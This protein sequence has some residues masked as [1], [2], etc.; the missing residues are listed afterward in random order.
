MTGIYLKCDKCG[1]T[2][3][4]E[5]VTTATNG[6]H[7]SHWPQL[8]AAARER[9]WTGPLTRESDSDRCPEC[10]KAETPNVKL[11]GERSESARTQG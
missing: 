4:G 2:L 3:G 8:Q 5:E 10:S 1:A 9:G 11:N 7:W 6:L